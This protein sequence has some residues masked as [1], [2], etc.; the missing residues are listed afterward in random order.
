MEMP[1]MVCNIVI[2][3][4]IPFI[5]WLI[6]VV[7]NK[8]ERKGM[9]MLFILGALFYAGM[10]WG[11][12]QHGLAYLFNH[13]DFQSFMEDHYIPYLLVVALAGAI[14]AVIPEWITIQLV[15]RRKVT[16]KQAIALGLG[17]TISETGFL[18]VYPG[19]MTFIMY[20]KEKETEFTTSAGELFLSGYERIL[21]TVIGT[22]LIVV[23]AYFIEQKM[24]IRGVIIKVISQMLIAFLPG[25]FIAFSTKN[26]LEVFDRS[27]TLGMVYVVLTAAC[28]CAI[29]VMNSLKWKMYENSK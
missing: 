14:L 17:Y 12:K 10:Q 20:F 25:F 28:L 5:I 24:V 21:L 18:I 26:Y 13:T 6:L 15:F 16:F 11:I 3:F 27:I 1:A 23:L 4:I 19:V 29:A 7:R 8:D 2:S 22:G 9:V